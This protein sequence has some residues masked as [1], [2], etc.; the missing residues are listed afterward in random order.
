M[1]YIKPEDRPKMDEIVN[2]MVYNGVKPDGKL[3]YILFK[4][5]KQTVAPESYNGYKKF[6]GEL[7]E[8]AAEIRRRLLSPYEDERI[9]EN[10]DVE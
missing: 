10:G 1:P 9:K 5:C 4:L 8:C 2:H 7:E 6:I 3:N